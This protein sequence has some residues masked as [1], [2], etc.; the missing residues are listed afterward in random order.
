ARPAPGHHAGTAPPRPPRRHDR[1][2]RSD[3]AHRNDPTRARAHHAGTAPPR[4]PR[5]HDRPTAPAR[6]G[7]TPHPAAPT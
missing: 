4:P 2:T 5:R 7:P 6:A 3:T 1:P